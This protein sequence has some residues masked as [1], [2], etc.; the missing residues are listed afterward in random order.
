MKKLESNLESFSRN[1]HSV[2]VIEMLGEVGI[3]LGM[4]RKLAVMEHVKEAGIKTLVNTKCIEFQ[5]DAV[6]AECKDEQQRILSDSVVVAVG[7]TSRDYAA[8]KTYCEQK[9]IPYSVIGDAKK[10]RKAIDAIAEAAEVARK[11]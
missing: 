4:Y 1:Q 2:T 5:K 3:D 9:G 8:L 11:I 10:P 6:I 7:S